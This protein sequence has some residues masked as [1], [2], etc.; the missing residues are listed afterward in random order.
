MAVVLSI[1]T[2]IRQ[3]KLSLLIAGPWP[4]FWL[5][6][7]HLKTTCYL[8]RPSSGWWRPIYLFW[9]ECQHFTIPQHAWGGE[10]PCWGRLRI[11]WAVCFLAGSNLCSLVFSQGDGVAKSRGDPTLKSGHNVVKA[12]YKTPRGESQPLWEDNHQ[13]LG[14]DRPLISTCCCSSST[15]PLWLPILEMDITNQWG[16]HL[17]A[18]YKS[19]FSSVNQFCILL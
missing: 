11:A 6:I 15:H 4:S 12:G 8:W 13:I 2:I 1:L 7:I 3:R 19:L 18:R 16:I 17:L 10:F 14:A 5:S 9:V